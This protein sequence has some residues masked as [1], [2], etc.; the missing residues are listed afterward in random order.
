M[1]IENFTIALRI[2]YIMPVVNRFKCDTIGISEYSPNVIVLDVACAY[3][4]LSTFC[5]LTSFE[6]T[7]ISILLDRSV[8]PGLLD[9]NGIKD[10]SKFKALRSYI[11]G[12]YLPLL[13]KAGL[14]V[15]YNLPHYDVLSSSSFYID[16]STI[17][18]YFEGDERIHGISIDDINNYLRKLWDQADSSSDGHDFSMD[19]HLTISNVFL[20]KHRTVY[21]IAEAYE[22]VDVGIDMTFGPLTVKPLCQREALIIVDLQ[23]IL[24]YNRGDFDR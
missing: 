11:M 6:A 12:S 5:V 19:D 21:S 3:V 14:H 10:E 20:A 16:Y 2:P 7:S 1:P 17:S 22:T 4:A 15:Y 24:F 18:N 8:L 13:K 23:E 9:Q